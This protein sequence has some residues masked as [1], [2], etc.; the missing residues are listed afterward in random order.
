MLV[1]VGKHNPREQRS[2]WIGAGL[3]DRLPDGQ[4]HLASSLPARAAT[5]FAAG[6]AYGQ[7]R[8]ERYKRGGPQRSVR[9]RTARRARMPRRWKD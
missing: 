4:Y 8:F 6:W 1:G 2:Y 9:L 3:A 7:Y 5:Q